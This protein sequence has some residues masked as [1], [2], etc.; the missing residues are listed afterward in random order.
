MS[1]EENKAMNRRF[2]EEVVNKQNVAAVDKLLS[3]NM[4]A[5]IL[6]PEIPPTRDGVKIFTGALFTAFPDAHATIMD[7]I[8]EGD[9]VTVRLTLTGTHKGMFNGIPPT[10]KKFEIQA[11]DVWRYDNG[12]GTEVWGGPDPM[13]IMQQLGLTDKPCK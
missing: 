4:V 5:H 10:G 7:Q 2:F 1:T 12:K 9:K 3:P 11:I 8:A 6:P 13:K